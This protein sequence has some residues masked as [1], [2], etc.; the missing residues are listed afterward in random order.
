MQYTSKRRKVV[1]VISQIENAIGFEWIAENLDSSRFELV[2]VMLNDK[3]SPLAIRLRK[4]GI[5]VYEEHF[6]T[7][8]D[9]PMVLLKLINILRKERAEVIHTHMFIADIVGQA[10][11]KLLRIKPRVYTRHSSNE[12]RK[13]HRKQR[14]DRFV[15]ASSSHVIAISKNVERILV[16]E[17]NVS[18]AKI[19]LIHHGFDLA[20]FDC[21]ADEEIAGLSSKYNPKKK[22]PV[23]GVVARY[24]HW[25]GIQYAIEAFKHL[26][27]DH[28][29][30]LLILANAKKGDYKDEIASLLRT[31]PPDSYHEIEFEANLFALYRLFDVYLHLPIDPELEAFGQTYVES[32]AA[33]VPSVFTLSGVAPEFVRN[34]Q[35]ALVVE[36]CDSDAV[37]RATSR[38]LSNP[39]L[40]Q[41]LSNRGKTDVREMF[42]LAGMIRKLE[43]LYSE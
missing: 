11:G 32:L 13:Y 14:I 31:L 7:K 17:E 8:R 20:R 10:A 34:E 25:K 26:I 6:R 3:P 35:N 38:L 29:N 18:P 43:E 5:R 42:L 16:S 15:N 23:I 22:S 33:G 2:F 28:P 19:R 37:Y 9:L 27:K 1:Y 21:V 36:F 39:E 4:L 12:N 41:S 24:S 40:C 30:A